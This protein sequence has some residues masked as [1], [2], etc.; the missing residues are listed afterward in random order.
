[1]KSIFAYLAL[2][3][4]PLLA[5]TYKYDFTSEKSPVQE[6]FVQITEKDSEHC[7][8]TTGTKVVSNFTPFSYEIKNSTPPPR[9]P[10][11]LSAGSVQGMFKAQ[12]T[13][14]KVASGKYHIWV[15]CGFGSA[16]PHTVWDVRM[17]AG[18]AVEQ[19]TFQGTNEIMDMH[20]E[21]EVQQGGLPVTI[22]SRGYW[23]LN[24]MG[25]VPQSEWPEV[26]DGWFKELWEEIFIL[27]KPVRKQWTHDPRPCT[28][29]EPRW[30]DRQK[31]DGLAVYT[32][33]WALPIWPDHF[34]LESELDAPVRAFASLGESEILNF[35]LYAL[36]DFEQVSLSVGALQGPQE[37]IFIPATEIDVRYVRY[38]YVRPN[39]N[40]H[41]VYYRAPDV[42]MP[43][44]RP[45]R[46]PKG[47]NLRF[48]LTVRTPL[49]TTP[50]IYKGEATV[51]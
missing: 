9:Y 38:M 17:K 42:L 34:P 30:S 32:R 12:F 26:R 21:T 46:L 44:R 16:A 14:P 33:N 39:Y 6:S 8:W 37:R 29:P 13:L 5:E 28:T 36:Q 35:T 24:A 7:K 23:V 40:L 15:L 51:K 43:Y 3:A 4:L 20:L 47:E 49:Y 2:F 31:S 27:P 45:M 19:L 25:L 10:I 22:E 48:W 18:D 11:N 41:G 1:M 50:G